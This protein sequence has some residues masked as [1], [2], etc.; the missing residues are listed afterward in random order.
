MKSNNITSI[1]QDMR[2][3]VIKKSG[4]EFHKVVFHIH[5]PASYDYGVYKKYDLSKID[6]NEIMII[7]KKFHYSDLFISSLDQIAGSL[8]YISNKRELGLYIILVS[9]LMKNG[10]K[11]ALIT[12]HNTLD[13]NYKIE[14]ACMVVRDELK[15]NPPKILYGIEV[16]CSDNH[17]V[18]LILDKDN[19]KM[20]DKTKKWITENI[21]SD[22]IG[23]YLPSLLV[24]EKFLEMNAF[25]YIA[26]FNTSNIFKEK[27]FL[28]SAYKDK[29]FY[30]DGM[31]I[32]GLNDMDRSQDVNIQLKNYRINRNFNFIL[33]ED[34]HILNDHGEKPTWLKAEDLNFKAIIDA[35]KDFKNSI[36][37]KENKSHGLKL[38]ALAL[39]GESF[40]KNKHKNDKLIIAFSPYMTSLIGG[41]GSGK[42]TILNTVEFLLGLDYKDDDV[43]N[44]IILQGESYL[45][46]KLNETEFVISFL[47]YD[48]TNFNALMQEINEKNNRDLMSVEEQI[49]HRRK[50]VLELIQIFEIKNGEAYERTD[51]KKLFESIKTNKFSIDS[52]VQSASTIKKTSNFLEYVMIDH[53]VLNKK[54]KL[55]PLN[56]MTKIIKEYRDLSRKLKRQ[57]DEK[58]EIINN[59]NERNSKFIKLTLSNH[60]AVDFSY[61]WNE[62]FKVF[63]D[64]LSNT[65][66]KYSITNA[67]LIEYFIALSK[68]YNPFN[69]IVMIMESRENEIKE[70]LDIRGYVLSDRIVFDKD[71]TDIKKQEHLFWEEI[72]RYF[73][74]SQKTLENELQ[75]YYLT[76]ENW[77]VEFNINNRT[78]I[79]SKN[80]K[81][82]HISKL[83]MGQKVVTFLN[84]IL[85]F[86]EFTD[87]NSPLIIDQPEDHLDNQYIYHNLVEK[88]RNLKQD[89]QIIIATHNSTIVVNSSSEQVIVMDSDAN[90]GWVKF[91]GYCKQPKIITAILD[92]LEG[93]QEAF[94]IKNRLYDSNLK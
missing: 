78:G 44:T 55:R 83:S 74:L 10:I 90:H 77:G 35:F 12:D 19:E 62:V 24:I 48:I 37:Y 65:F 70:E 60:R 41:R 88:F 9:K 64:T 58:I 28:N 20:M 59:F 17:H 54:I 21:I 5:T 75:R 26:H 81:Y 72:R 32:I 47:G 89:R 8:K 94:K 4:A 15:M 91:H 6:I 11:L 53:K 40:L 79:P 56:N 57:S 51:K 61:S 2:K 49:N 86:N 43:F 42:S 31:D 39:E 50:K 27:R 29:L 25:A 67:G 68:I 63:R 82:R 52:I 23:T 1:Y 7:L 87:D 73:T 30:L 3:H 18:V 45:Y 93:G 80:V 36:A 76:A 84:F 16:S 13:G 34:S 71:L 38:L 46:L 85:A 66:R 14:E 69:L 22:E 33:D 92:I